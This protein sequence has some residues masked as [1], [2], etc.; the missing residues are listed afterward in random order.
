MENSTDVPAVFK[1]ILYACYLKYDV[2]CDSMILFLLL[3]RNNY[4]RRNNKS[5]DFDSF[6]LHMRSE[7]STGDPSQTRPGG[8]L[9]EAQQAQKGK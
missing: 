3:E 5:Y 1:P 8:D 4:S 7:S 2:Y 9:H 6:S